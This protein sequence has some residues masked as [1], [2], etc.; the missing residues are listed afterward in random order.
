MSETPLAGT[1]LSREILG[2]VLDE[3]GKP[4]SISPQPATTF[5]EQIQAAIDRGSD[6]DSIQRRFHLS[7]SELWDYCSD[8]MDDGFDEGWSESASGY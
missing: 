8:I 3:R 6:L 5:A 7:E 1:D 2:A 4:G